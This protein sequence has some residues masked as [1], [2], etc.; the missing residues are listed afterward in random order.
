MSRDW[1][2]VDVVEGNIDIEAD[3]LTQQ[4]VSTLLYIEARIVDGGAMLNESQMNH[5][6]TQNMKLFKA[7]GMLSVDETVSSSQREVTEF[8][9]EAWDLAAQLRKRR[10]KQNLQS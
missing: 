2:I 3:D 9:D 6:D 7:A 8:T 4:E 10:G 5:D 1:D